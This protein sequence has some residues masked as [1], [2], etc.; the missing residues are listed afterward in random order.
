MKA[1]KQSAILIWLIMIV[2]IFINLKSALF[3]ADEL[4][5]Q[6][7]TTEVESYLETTTEPQVEIETVTIVTT[8]ISTTA[9][10]A[11]KISAKKGGNF[12][13]YTDYQCLSKKSPQWKLQEQAY[14]DENGL[15]KIDEYY[16]VALG[17]YYGTELGTKYLVTLSTGSQFKIILCDC[18]SDHHTDELN[19]TCLVN[20]SILEFYVE[21]NKLSKSVKTA[22]SIGVLPEFAGEVENIEKIV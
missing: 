19:Q 7:I 20:G 11:L 4:I 18:K 21:T 6:P 22:G 5:N 15:R 12:K 14:T 17:S 16:L 9:T 2:F 10:A 8:Q 1:T 3:F 13:S